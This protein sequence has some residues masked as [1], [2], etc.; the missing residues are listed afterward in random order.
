MTV[1]LV[2]AVA[3][4]GVIGRANRLPWRLPADLKRFKALTMGHPVIMGRRTYESIGK[5]LPGRTNIVVT[6]QSGYRA[7]GCL[8]AGSLEQALALCRRDETA[9]VIGGAMLYAEALP[10]ATR[11]YLTEIRQAVEGDTLFP[12]FDR[13]RWRETIREDHPAEAGSPLPYSF[14]TLERCD[15]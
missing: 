11:I 3:E 7:E 9:F 2:C 1:A 4:N 14:V 6:R 5:P 12:E 8:V 15:A 13:T 10:A